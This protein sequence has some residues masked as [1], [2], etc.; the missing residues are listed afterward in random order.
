MYLQTG[1]SVRWLLYEKLPL[2]SSLCP[3]WQIWRGHKG[4]RH[5]WA[6]A[7]HLTVGGWRAFYPTWPQQSEWDLFEKAMHQQQ[8]HCEWDGVQTIH[9]IKC[10]S[11]W[12]ACVAPGRKWVMQEHLKGV[13]WNSKNS[14]TGNWI[15]NDTKWKWS[16]ESGRAAAQAH[17]PT[18]PLRRRGDAG[19]QWRQGSSK[20]TVPCE[21]SQLM[22]LCAVWVGGVSLQYYG[23]E[24]NVLLLWFFFC[25]FL[26]WMYRKHLIR[27]AN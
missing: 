11:E 10:G 25:V 17:V 7:A 15:S 13:L 20:E 16:C 24:M 4:F 6:A 27:C 5:S 1:G 12:K 2:L 3:R 9:L 23:S 14:F 22:M 26:F 21:K 8:E 18:I 19:G